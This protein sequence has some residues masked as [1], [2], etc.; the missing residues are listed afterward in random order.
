MFKLSLEN[1]LKV[2]SDLAY[3]Y[4]PLGFACLNLTGETSSKKLFFGETRGLY[5]RA[6]LLNLT[7]SAY[8]SFS[9]LGSLTVLTTSH[10]FWTNLEFALNSLN[11]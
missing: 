9:N 11:I 8:R 7:A 3:P 1:L 6:K 5:L 2:V 4:P 10:S